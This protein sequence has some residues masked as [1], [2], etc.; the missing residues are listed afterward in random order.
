[1]ITRKDLDDKLL[2]SYVYNL[3]T[4]GKDNEWGEVAMNMK[5]LDSWKK[6]NGFNLFQNAGFQQQVNNKIKGVHDLTIGDLYEWEQA[7]YENICKEITEL[8]ELITKVKPKPVN[9]EVLAKVSRLEQEMRSFDERISKMAK[10]LNENRALLD[11]AVKIAKEPNKEDERITTLWNAYM[12]EKKDEAI[13]LELQ[14]RITIL[15]NE[16][17]NNGEV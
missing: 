6:F 4:L 12:K 5:P 13:I 1:M 15:E 2:Q 11:E 10:Y 17:K 14:R 16:V 9:E 3:N 8:K 7:D